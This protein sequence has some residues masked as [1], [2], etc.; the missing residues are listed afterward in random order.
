[1]RRG[2]PEADGRGRGAGASAVALKRVPSRPHGAL[3]RT[4][5]GAARGRGAEAPGAGPHLDGGSAHELAEPGVE[6]GQG[7][8]AAAHDHQ[9][10]C[11]AATGRQGGARGLPQGRA[12]RENLRP[13]PCSRAAAAS[14]LHCACTAATLSAREQLSCLQGPRG[15]AHR[16]GPPTG[17]RCRPSSTQP[18]PASSAWAPPGPPGC[19]RPP[20]PPWAPRGRW[21]PPGR[22]AGAGRGGGCRAMGETRVIRA[23][24]KRR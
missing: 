11:G 12:G 18:P 22:P 6:R 19:P 3:V 17:E 10:G 9:S 2:W 23:Q 13:R 20:W 14:R 4:G 24:V 8:G 1:V 21:P 7:K 16:A 15:V 5:A